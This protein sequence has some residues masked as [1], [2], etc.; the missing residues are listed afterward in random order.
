MAMRS[1]RSPWYLMLPS[2][3]TIADPEVLSLF[4]RMEELKRLDYEFDI[5]GAWRHRYNH[6]RMSNVE[7]ARLEAKLDAELPDQCRRW[8]ANVGKGAGPGY[9]L[10]CEPCEPIDT[11]TDNLEPE[12]RGPLP[13]QAVCDV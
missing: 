12:L 3:D 10:V 6:D 9:G 1:C 13:P 5:H 2:A 7:L 8:L 4:N 11:N